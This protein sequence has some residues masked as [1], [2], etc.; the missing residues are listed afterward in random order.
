MLPKI[1]TTITWFCILSFAAISGIGEGL[2][3]LP[4]CGHAVSA[5]TGYVWMGGSI[6][7]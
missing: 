4:G 1:R 2:H 5:G 6:L 7:G 3:F